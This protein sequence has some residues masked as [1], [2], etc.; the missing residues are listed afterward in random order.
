MNNKVL[1]QQTKP[2]LEQTPLPTRIIGRIIIYLLLIGGS[3]SMIFPFL[4]LVRSSFMSTAQI[5]I[6]PP[7]WVPNPFLWQNYPEALTVVP[8]YRYLLNTLVLEFWNITGTLFTCSLAAFSFARLRWRGRNIVF[9]IILSGLMLPYAVTLIPHYLIWN[10]LGAVNT[11]L[12]LTVPSWLGQHVFAIFLLRQFFMTI[13]RDLDEAAYIDGANPFTV[14]FRV[15][16]PLSKPAFIVVFIFTFIGVWNDFLGPLIY[17]QDR[18][19]FT[20]A[21]GLAQFSGMYNAQWGYLMAAST[22]MIAPIIAMFFVAQKYFIEGI[23][24]TGVKG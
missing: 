23:T 2:K 12:P 18:E 5:F 13:P 17:L 7:E 8:F 20:L 6:F 16:I 10:S 22:A 21:V 9:G 11:I 15:I 24:L 3:I 1:I 14:L 19:K 4:W